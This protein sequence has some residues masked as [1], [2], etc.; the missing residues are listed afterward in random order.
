MP[1]PLPIVEESLYKQICI[2][3]AQINR[4]A[5]VGQD[6]E[7]GQSAL[8]NLLSSLN[9]KPNQKRDDESSDLETTPLGVWAKRWEDNRPIPDSDVPEPKLIKY[10]S[11]WFL[12]HLAKSFGLKNLNS[13][14]YEDEMNK[15]RVTKPE[16]EGDEDDEL[17]VDLFGNSDDHEGDGNDTA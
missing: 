11:V 9:V 5:S 12:G 4:K 10:I 14:L 7:K 8:N 3:E 16:Y 15:Y 17:L 2:Q 13:Q 6:V 1:K